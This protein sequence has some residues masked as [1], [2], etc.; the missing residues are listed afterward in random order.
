MKSSMIENTLKRIIE[1]DE[2]SEMIKKE[3]K[4]LRSSKKK[5]LTQRMRKIEREYM[6]SI[7]KDTKKTYN[8]LIN[9]GLEEV[10]FIE[11]RISKKCDY[12]RHVLESSKDNIVKEIC[13]ELIPV[14]CEG[15]SE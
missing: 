9:E 1:I 8:Q 13:Q 14:K 2:E 11:E 6:K 5:E 7:R 10:E 4:N 15:D 12:L 3:I